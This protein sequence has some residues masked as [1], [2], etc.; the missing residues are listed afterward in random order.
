MFLVTR[1]ANLCI[2]IIIINT[3]NF[4]F[5]F[6]IDLPPKK[7]THELAYQLLGLEFVSVA[8]IVSSRK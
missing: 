7:P 3:A 8:G 2:F 6:Y 4:T 5:T 1:L